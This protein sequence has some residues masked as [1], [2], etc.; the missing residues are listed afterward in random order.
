MSPS[1]CAPFATLTAPPSVAEQELKLPSVIKTQPLCTVKPFREAKAM[2]SRDTRS[3]LLVIVTFSPEAA[4]T[5]R[6]A[7]GDP[8]ASLIISTS[9]V[10]EM[11]EVSVVFVCRII[12]KEPAAGVAVELFTRFAAWPR[13]FTGLKML[14]VPVAVPFVP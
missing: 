2:F 14:P 7:V 10:S 11:E 3:A 6:S 1:N 8:A 13:V 4:V 5:V 12:L 9:F